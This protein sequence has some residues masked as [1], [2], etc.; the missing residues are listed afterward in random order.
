MPDLFNQD[1]KCVTTCLLCLFLFV[2][3]AR[4]QQEERSGLENGEIVSE[5]EILSTKTEEEMRLRTQNSTSMEEYKERLRAYV[6]APRD[7]EE[8]A[9][10]VDSANL[11]L[12]QE[13]CDWESL[14]LAMGAARVGMQGHE[15]LIGIAETIFHYPRG[16]KLSDAHAYCLRYAL[17]VMGSLDSPSALDLLIQCT[18]DAYW[19]EYPIRSPRLSTT[20]SHSKTMLR[21]GAYE[22]IAQCSAE[23]CLPILEQMEKDHPN[24]GVA[25]PAT[26]QNYR[27]EN[28]LGFMI[29]TLLWEVRT[30][31]G[32]EAGPNPRE[33]AMRKMLAEK[34]IDYDE[35]LQWSKESAKNNE[36]VR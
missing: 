17:E 5:L 31:E 28:E 27:L 16:E 7:N 36:Q 23:L 32:M 19:S 12:Q 11:A 8:A 6:L 13:P 2:P 34:G 1:F 14:K 10:I 30:R 29:A 21:I 9:L 18:A 25:V 4:A 20:A 35:L 15:E 3:S 33:V 26:D 22:A 24:L